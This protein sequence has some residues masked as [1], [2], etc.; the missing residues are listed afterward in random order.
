[1]KRRNEGG[2]ILVWKVNVR[3]RERER[4]VTERE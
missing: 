2:M 1:M 4:V 3:E